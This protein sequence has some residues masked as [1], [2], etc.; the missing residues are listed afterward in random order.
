MFCANL[1]AQ[2]D[3][4]SSKEEDR[5][6]KSQKNAF[7]PFE[8]L[9]TGIIVGF[10]PEYYEIHEDKLYYEP[11]FPDK[12]LTPYQDSISKIEDYYNE[13][14]HSLASSAYQYSKTLPDSIKK[15]IDVLYDSLLSETLDY[16]GKV[17]KYR[18]LKYEKKD[19]VEAFI[20]ESYEY[21]NRYFGEP[22]IW[23]GYSENSG[24]DWCYYYTGIVQRQPVFVKYYSQKPLIKEK[25]RL[26]I[27]ACLL[28]QLS[29]FTHPLP[30]PTYEC[31]K[32]GIYLVF[33]MNIIA[34]DSDGDGLTDIA[35][36]KLYL[37]KY[38]NDTDGDGIPDNL[39]TNP[40]LYFPRTEKSRIYEAIMNEEIDWN[41]RG[42]GISLFND[43]MTYYVTDTTETI[44]I[45]TNDKDLL[46]IQ[47]QKYRVIFITTDEY[48]NHAKVYESELN[49]MGFSP[50][51]KVDKKRNTY[52][53]SYSFNT[54][55]AEYL[56]RKTKKG[57]NIKILSMWIS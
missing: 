11:Y 13:K 36:D 20:Y 7:S 21:E 44:L 33:D 35:E 30:A 12:Y 23:I 39:D 28:R 52:K 31:V 17:E 34:K 9:D 43:N 19:N 40:R 6:Y 42:V 55:G 22:G 38:N 41:K 53:M 26:E 8:P 54:W 46:G 50:L 57:W 49:I 48:K 14:I 15:K 45:V 56:I 24:K 1:F 29:E 47:P 2:K 51:F 32:D 25:G 27:E 18:I 37:D 5:Y 16:I 3:K 10:K 4:Y